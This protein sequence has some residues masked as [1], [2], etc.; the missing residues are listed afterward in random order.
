M[1]AGEK[2]SCIKIAVKDFDMASFAQGYSE[3]TT[4]DHR[5]GYV[6]ANG[7]TPHDG[8]QWAVLGHR[9]IITRVNGTP[10]RCGPGFVAFD[11]NFRRIPE[12]WTLMRIAIADRAHQ[13]HTMAWFVLQG[14][15]DPQAIT[16]A[17]VGLDTPTSLTS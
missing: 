2:E 13:C 17:L 7:T 9:D 6:I 5:A 12:G 1:S 8:K 16:C 3:A 4:H 15:E 11:G 14:K 10:N